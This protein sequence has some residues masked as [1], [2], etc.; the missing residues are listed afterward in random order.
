MFSS[1][2]TMTKP[3]LQWMQS[4]GL[5]VKLEFITPWGMCDLV[6][7]SFKKR[8]RTA[9]LKLGQTQP[10][11][12]LIGAA[13]LAQIP[14]A[15]THRTTTLRRLKQE[16]FPTISEDTVAEQIQR[17]IADGF[18]L[19]SGANRLQKLN[20]WIPLHKRLIAIELKLNR[21]EE[22]LSQARNNLIF[23]DKS[24]V[25][26]PKDVAERV[27]ASRTRRSTFLNEGVGLVS[28]SSRECKILIPSRQRPS[29]PDPVIQFYCVEKFWR[30]HSKGS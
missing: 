6:G 19:S 11:G 14:D 28:V 7:L 20:G 13:L 3:V 5:Q 22:A 8:A 10:I 4:L 1:E 12:S 18:V 23:A 16:C 21:V 15:K 27:A 24:Y 25:G 9:R 30:T 29:G 26:L 2:A 17:L